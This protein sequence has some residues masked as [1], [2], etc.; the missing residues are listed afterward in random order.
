MVL[1]LTTA[2]GTYFRIS[3]PQRL[4]FVKNGSF[5]DVDRGAD[6]DYPLFFPES[7]Y[8]REELTDYVNTIK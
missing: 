7:F 6:P 2:Y 4:A 1:P 8:D 5:Y 3:G